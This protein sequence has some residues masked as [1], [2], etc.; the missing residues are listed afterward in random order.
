MW[1]KAGEW[2]SL[3]V[4]GGPVGKES[5]CSSRDLG[6]IPGWEDPLEKRWTYRLEKLCPIPGNL[7]S[8]M[9]VWMCTHSG[10]H[11]DSQLWFGV[12]A[13]RKRRLSHGPNSLAK[14][15]RIAPKVHRTLQRKTERL[16]VAN[17]F[18]VQSLSW[19]LRQQTENSMAHLKRNTDFIE[20]I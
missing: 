19:P 9:H 16:L 13:N 4:P 7:E 17:E 10:K 6:W 5:A 14:C 8:Q 15:Q 1:G 12:Y 2:D 3:G 20:L 18:S 11:W